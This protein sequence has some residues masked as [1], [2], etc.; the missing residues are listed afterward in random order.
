MTDEIFCLFGSDFQYKAAAW[1]YR[2]LDA[3]IKYMNENHGDKYFFKY[4]SPSKYIDSI[5]K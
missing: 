2:N 3:M 5:K 4:S 1:N